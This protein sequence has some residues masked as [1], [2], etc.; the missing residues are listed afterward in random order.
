MG[1][2]DLC[3]TLS[4][5]GVLS[6]RV[7]QSEREAY[8]DLRIVPRRNIRGV[9]LPPPHTTRFIGAKI[10]KHTESL[11]FIFT[12]FPEKGESGDVETCGPLRERVKGS[13]GNCTVSRFISCIVHRV[14]IGEPCGRYKTCTQN[15]VRETG[16]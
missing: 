14:F 4:L 2:Q 15:F 6:P 7:K 9:I 5:L 8:S 16:K 1:E 13:E 10:V 12:Y 3:L 11:T